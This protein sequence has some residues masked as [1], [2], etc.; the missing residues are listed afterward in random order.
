VVENLIRLLVQELI[1]LFL[2]VS[3]LLCQRVSG[4]DGA[5]LLGMINVRTLGKIYGA[6]VV[7]LAV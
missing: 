7:L 5:R 3:V 1:D 2:L 4:A 6:H